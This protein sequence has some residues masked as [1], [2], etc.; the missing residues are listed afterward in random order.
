MN[1]DNPESQNKPEN[2]NRPEAS[3]DQVPG[4]G[5]S[6]QAH[7]QAGQ[8]PQ[9][10]QGAPAQQGHA[11]PQYQRP[12]QQQPGQAPHQGPPPQQF[13]GPPRQGPPFQQQ[14]QQQNFQGPPQ[15]GPQF[16]GPPN[17]QG[18][19]PQ[20]MGGP[21]P[22]APQ[23]RKIKRSPWPMIIGLVILLFVGGSALI[24]LI[25]GLAATSGGSGSGGGGMFSF[26][27]KI[28]VLD[29]QG[30]IG[31]GDVYPADT[32]RLRKLVAKWKNDDSIKG[33]I[34]RV[35]SPGGA[36]SATQDLFTE[37]NEFRSTGKPVYT[38]MGDV[39]ASGGYYLA[40]A[41]DEIWVNSG[42]LTGSIGV[43]LSFYGYEDLF[44]KLGLEAR[45]IKSGEFKDIGSGTRPMTEEE[46]ALLDE[47]VDDVFEQFFEVVLDNRIEVVREMVALEKEEETGVTVN[48]S[49]ITDEE[50]EA[51]LREYCDGRIF[52]GR[53]AI[54]YGM[55]DRE[56]TLQ[57]SLDAMR[58]Q[59][60]L[61]NDSPVVTTPVPAPG[62]FGTFDQKMKQMEQFTP[63]SIHLEFRFTM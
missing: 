1:Q 37:I 33:M 16:G 22:N 15:G 6:Q 21:P 52:S 31:A 18:P 25:S 17:F 30:M 60:G 50:V 42:T 13:Q 3:S 53:Q 45:S 40:M 2:P 43:I 11:T 7:P 8:P 26:G 39:A 19:P 20:G 14:N 12:P 56:G 29:V 27:D 32:E 34:I 55:A 10:Q 47:M 4:S 24:A 9:G 57:E 23:P 35:N 38:S 59:L 48:I 63:G 51:Y 44:D 49:S 62:L 54:D 28:A 5:P 36:V 58:N 41:S 61:P 46:K